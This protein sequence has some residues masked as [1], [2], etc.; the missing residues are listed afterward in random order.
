LGYTFWGKRE[1]LGRF[2]G[3]ATTIRI[4]GME[5]ALFSTTITTATI[6]TATTT[7]AAAAAAAEK[8]PWWGEHEKGW[9]EEWKGANGVT[10]FQLKIY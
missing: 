10:R 4:Y 1:N 2:W 8:E 6:T 7:I 5:K 3:R 9:R